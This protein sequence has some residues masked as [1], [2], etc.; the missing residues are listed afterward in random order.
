MS[1]NYTQ[2]P[3][4]F[5]RGGSVSGETR[6]FVKGKETSSKQIDFG[7]DEF[8]EATNAKATDET[9]GKGK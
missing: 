7:K 1:K 5:A 3:Q 2:R 4:Q 6:S 8:R 9:W